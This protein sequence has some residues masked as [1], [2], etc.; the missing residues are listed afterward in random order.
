MANPLLIDVGP[1]SCGCTDHLLETLAKA[2]SAGD[3]TLWAPHHDPWV[4]NHIESITQRML[5]IFGDIESALIQFLEAGTLVKSLER[6][7]AEQLAAAR[8]RLE[9]KSADSFTHDD[10]MR[11]IDWIIQ[12][13]LP[14]DVVM[15]ESEYLAVR[16]Y[17]AGK[18]QAATEGRP[19][20]DDQKARLMAAAP[21]AMADISVF[22]KPSGLEAAVLQFANA[23]AVELVTDIGERVRHR[24]KS[25]IIAHEEN[26]AIGSPD[27]SISRLQQQFLDEFA[28]LNRDWRRIAI[29][30]TARNAN[31]GFLAALPAGSKVRRVEA[32]AT[33]CPFCKKLHGMEFTVVSPAKEHKN[34]WAE[35]WVGK[36]N[37]GRSSSPRKREGDELVERAEDEM[38]WPA[39]GTQHPNCRGTWVRISEVPPGVDPKFK[40]WLDNELEK[41]H[42]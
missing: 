5:A 29:T 8:R 22:G 21:S 28:V 10:W 24:M 32:Y 37:V 30:E 17:F 41:I 20:S 27:A 40:A 14:D 25:L 38:W 34:G 4:R 18:L 42:E 13:Y 12:R 9:Q 19:L 1:L 15:T 35:V 31:E 2:Q 6:M 26:T 7:T 11:L 33:A 3:D 23:R 16:S 39:A 36:T